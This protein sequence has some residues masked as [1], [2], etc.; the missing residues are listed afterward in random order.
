MFHDIKVSGPIFKAMSGVKAVGVLIPYFDEPPAPGETV[1]VREVYASR[2]P[3]G[4]TF[5]FKIATSHFGEHLGLEKGRA[6]VIPER[7]SPDDN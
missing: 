2:K 1:R 3:T 6:F 5:E 7:G 4:R